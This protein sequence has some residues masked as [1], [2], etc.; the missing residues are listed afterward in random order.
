MKS[1]PNST[2]D[3]KV[4]ADAIRLTTLSPPPSSDPQ[5]SG[6]PVTLLVLAVIFTLGVATCVF[7][8]GA[9][10]SCRHRYPSMPPMDQ[11]ERDRLV[12]LQSVHTD[13][14][15]DL[16]PAIALPDGEEFPYS[17]TFLQIRDTEQQ[18]EIYRECIKPPP[19]RT[20]FDG[21]DRHHCCSSTGLLP[22]KSPTTTI[23]AI[24]RDWN[25]S[26]LVTRSHRTEQSRKKQATVGGFLAQC[27]QSMANLSAM[28]GL[29]S[30]L[31]SVSDVRVTD[32]GLIP[33]LTSAADVRVTDSS[34]IS[35]LASSANIGVTDKGQKCELAG[36]ADVRVTD[37]GQKCVLA[38]AADSSLMSQLTGVPDNKP[39]VITCESGKAVTDISSVSAVSCD[40]TG[41]CARATQLTLPFTDDG[42]L[43]PPFTVW[44][45]LD[46]RPHSRQ[47]NRKM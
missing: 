34:L 4:A 29:R 10:H 37:K 38:D 14:R 16:P 35:H 6:F 40:S 12:R 33:R 46:E 28:G 26:P 15:L 17:G 5:V 8:T 44:G 20:I 42:Q 3:V 2:E 43:T 27:T 31:A 9:L 36:A 23:V 24:E 32:S 47:T 21:V 7:R 25:S 18:S 19:N 30:Q 22:Q 41:R 1:L 13:L 45:G 11:T 39:S